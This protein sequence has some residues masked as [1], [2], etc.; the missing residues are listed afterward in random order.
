[1]EDAKLFV[2]VIAKAG[3]SLVGAFL[4]PEIAVTVAGGLIIMVI[5][6]GA[7]WITDKWTDFEAKLIEKGLEVWDEL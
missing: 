4:A 6:S 2:G 1:M 3:L 5:A 7:V